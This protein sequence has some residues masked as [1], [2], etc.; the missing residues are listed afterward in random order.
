M[1]SNFQ[2]S[3]LSLSLSQI[4]VMSSFFISRSKK[5]KK[6]RR[7]F[8]VFL[9]FSNVLS[10]TKKEKNRKT[11][12]VVFFIS[13]M[14]SFI[15]KKKNREATF[16]VFSFDRISSSLS[17]TSSFVISKSSLETQLFSSFSSFMLKNIAM[18]FE[19]FVTN[20]F[21]IFESR[22]DENFLAELIHNAIS[23]FVL[24]SRSFFFVSFFFVSF[25]FVS[26]VFLSSSDASRSRKRVRESFSSMS[27]K[28][29]DSAKNKY[30]CIMSRKRLERLTQI[31]RIQNVRQTKH[32]L[33][34]LYYLKKQICK[35]H[36]KQMRRL[37]DLL[38]MEDLEKM[39]DAL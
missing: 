33:S 18:M 14:L 25:S 22:F 13:K 36:I 35:N 12:F 8:F 19:A 7:T 1:C 5:K 10:L 37:Y 39:K 26:F 30:D 4:V 6:N 29:V 16:V 21:N 2:L 20:V 32:L 28:K 27:R 15:E 9:F 17:S 23:S 24:S 34:V 11:I 38:S 3:T 31:N